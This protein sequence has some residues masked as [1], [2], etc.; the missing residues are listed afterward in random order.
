MESGRIAGM[1]VKEREYTIE[2]NGK[3]RARKDVR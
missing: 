2:G 3:M 1:R